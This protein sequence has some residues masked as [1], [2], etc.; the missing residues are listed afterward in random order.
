MKFTKLGVV[1]AAATFAV[2]AFADAA[3][4]LVSFS[5]TE[6]YYLDGNPVVDGE[7]YALC[8]SADGSFDGLNI[9]CTP[10]DSSEKVLILAP[11]AKDG[12]CPYT[13]FQMA[14]NSVPNY[15]NFYVYLLDTRDVTK[16]SAASSTKVAGRNIPAT[17]VNGSATTTSKFS[18]NKSVSVTSTEANVAAA[19]ESGVAW[20]PVRPKITAFEVDPS[21][22]TVKITVAGMMS[23]IDYKVSMGANI[24]EMESYNVTPQTEDGEAY[25]TIQQDDARFFQV[26]T[27]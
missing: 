26:V 27:E 20:V 24:N 18:V 3:N 10:V 6:D 5:T 4:V 22:T 9:D 17:T 2:G 7:W 12:H 13:L 16:T 23:G 21:T 8:W 11:L 19:A 25:F 1:L 15:G 14:A